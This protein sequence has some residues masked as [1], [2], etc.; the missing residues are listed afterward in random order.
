[1]D[2]VDDARLHT[3]GD[4]DRCSRARQASVDM[5][6]SRVDEKLRTTGMTC[7]GSMETHGATT[8]IVHAKLNVKMMKN[9]L[10]ELGPFTK[11][12]ALC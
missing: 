10:V 2:V 4:N 8:P 12:E 1:M 5:V 9:S 11:V 7:A 3:P 6:L